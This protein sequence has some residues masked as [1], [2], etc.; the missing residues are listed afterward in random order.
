MFVKKSVYEAVGGFSEDLPRHY[1]DLDFCLKLK[2]RGY[3]C[4][5]DPAVEV[6]H[7]DPADQQD[8]STVERERLH[9]KHPN[10]SDP[11][12]NKWFDS[13]DPSFRV[14]LRNREAT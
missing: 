14:S 10:L 6:Y 2:Q 7:S 12:F 1:N 5:V 9:M 4:V 8:N 3:A 13:T 11:Y